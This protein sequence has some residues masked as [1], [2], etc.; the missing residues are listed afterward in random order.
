MNGSFKGT[1]TGQ[2]CSRFLSSRSGEV[3]RE[4]DAENTVELSVRV[5]R[6]L[7]SSPSLHLCPQGFSE[8]NGV[9]SPVGLEWDHRGQYVCSIQNSVWHR[10]AQ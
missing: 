4:E 7:F 1:G 5:G 3:R 6:T 10:D 9:P 8:A 2:L